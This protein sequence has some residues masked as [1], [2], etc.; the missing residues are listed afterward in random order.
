MRFLLICV[1][2]PTAYVGVWFHGV[3]W[4]TISDKIRL[5]VAV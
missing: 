4:Q 3:K 1:N 2:G 5:S